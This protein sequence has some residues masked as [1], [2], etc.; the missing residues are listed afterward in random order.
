VAFEIS[1]S[2]LGL[3]WNAIAAIGATM[4][5]TFTFLLWRTAANELSA[6]LDAFRESAKDRDAEISELKVQG[7]LLR[8]QLEVAKEVQQQSLLPIVLLD[9][10]TT[11]YQRSLNFGYFTNAARSR[12]FTTLTGRN[13]GPGPARRIEIEVWIQKTALPEDWEE[14]TILSWCDEHDAEVSFSGSAAICA[15][16]EHFRLRWSEWNE[17]TGITEHDTIIWR[18]RYFDVFGTG[19]QRA[20]ID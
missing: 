3:D 9:P 20:G 17:D 4:A 5:A 19:R 16:G 7:Q 11:F 13:V 15:P 6:V 12:N 10:Y 18:A 8:E 2:W 1:G 14:S